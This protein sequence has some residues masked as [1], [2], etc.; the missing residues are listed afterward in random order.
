MTMRAVF[1]D[2][3]PLRIIFSLRHRIVTGQAFRADQYDLFSHSK[4]I[5]PFRTQLK[6]I[7]SIKGKPTLS[8]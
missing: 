8:T 3:N 4:I 5:S 6:Y 7:I 1:H 2:F